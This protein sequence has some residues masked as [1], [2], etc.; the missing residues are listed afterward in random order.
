VTHAPFVHFVQRDLGRH[1]HA[2]STIRIYTPLDLPPHTS[3]SR[4]NLLGITKN[5]DRSPARS[6]WL[7]LCIIPYH[8]TNLITYNGSG[9]T[10]TTCR[11][12]S[13]PS[14]C[15]SVAGLEQ[16]QQSQQ[17]PSTRS[18]CSRIS[19]TTTSYDYRPDAPSLCRSNSDT[20]L[21]SFATRYT[22]RCPCCRRETGIYT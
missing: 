20:D 14:T 9:P 4:C 5:I 18:T 11:F 22:T 3:S 21:V 17:Q 15:T 10:P 13:S 7:P 8:A 16:T 12:C 19:S 1:I 6:L 2:I